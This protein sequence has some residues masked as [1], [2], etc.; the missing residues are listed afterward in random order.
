M[1]LDEMELMAYLDGE[2]APAE[3]ARVAR[4]IAADPQLLAQVA[5]QQALR[6][7]IAGALRGQLA[8]PV[9]ARLVDAARTAPAGA[10]PVIHLDAHRARVAVARGASVRRV[11]PWSVAAA[12]CLALVLVVALRT[13][14]DGSEGPGPWL[15]DGRVFARGDIAT[16]LD[17]SIAAQPG[18]PQSV[19]VGL[20]FRDHAGRYCRAFESVAARSAGLACHEP[21]GWVLERVLPAAPGTR[22]GGEGLRQAA[23][24]WPAALLEEVDRRIAGD[25]LDAAGERAAQ[26]R[27]WRP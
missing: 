19:Q 14:G 12:A 24:G 25:P 1:P 4:E 26:A 11:V 23:S 27:G 17:H 15:Q 22:A 20:S 9:P 3:C 21:A 2:L 16:A 18:A 7:R 10:A 8:E 13:A 6:G 5:R